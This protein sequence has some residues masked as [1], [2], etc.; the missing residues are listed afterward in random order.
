MTKGVVFK[1]D[2]VDSRWIK[3]DDLGF[4]IVDL[5]WVCHKSDCFILASHAIV[6]SVG[7]KVNKSVCSVGL[8][9]W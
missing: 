5:N 3:I 6:C 2:W 4:T 8:L 1:C 7:L 9:T